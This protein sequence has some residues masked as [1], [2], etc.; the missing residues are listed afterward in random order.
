[1][2]R[3]IPDVEDCKEWIESIK[4]CLDG[5]DLFTAYNISVRDFEYGYEDKELKKALKNLEKA[6][7]ELKEVIE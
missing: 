1:M 7:E 4:N 2:T 5:V 6:Y 3:D